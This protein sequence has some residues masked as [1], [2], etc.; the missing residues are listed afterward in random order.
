[1]QYTNTALETT[2]LVM[3]DSD[4]FLYVVPDAQFMTWN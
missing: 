4:T 3:Y 2:S 1:M